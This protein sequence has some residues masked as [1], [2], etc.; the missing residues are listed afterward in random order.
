[1]QTERWSTKAVDGKV[2]AAISEL[3]NAAPSSMRPWRR[4]ATSPRRAAK[5]V[6]TT[7]DA[8]EA[9]TP[10][11]P[12]LAVLKEFYSKLE[13]Q[14]LGET[15]GRTADPKGKP[16]QARPPFRKRRRGERKLAK[17]LKEEGPAVE[18]QTKRTDAV[19]NDKE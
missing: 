17:S 8:E 7:S 19:E 16:K 5:D 4:K 12:A 6:E 13:R 3:A 18:A 10:D 2:K 15:E 11:T 9:K 14:C 1:M